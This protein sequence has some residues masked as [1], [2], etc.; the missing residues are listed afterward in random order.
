MTVVVFLALVP[1]Y[2]YYL[3]IQWQIVDGS[4]FG[5]TR[6]CDPQISAVSP[7]DTLHFQDF[8]PNNSFNYFATIYCHDPNFKK[9]GLQI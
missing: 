4:F 8:K 6:E 9:K 3:W 2:N 1:S 7:N 5:S